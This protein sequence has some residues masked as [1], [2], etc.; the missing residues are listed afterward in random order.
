MAAGTI[1]TLML[2]TEEVMNSLA[3]DP[4]SEQKLDNSKLFT[5]IAISAPSILVQAS[6]MDLL[7]LHR[8]GVA[9][10]MCDH[11]QLAEWFYTRALEL[12]VA[13]FGSLSAEATKH[14]NFLA[15]LY[16]AWK[17]FALAEQYVRESLA[18]Y[19]CTLG[20][21]H[22][23]T[24]MTWFA[25]ALVLMQEKK[26]Q[27]SQDAYA[28]CNLRKGIDA[29]SNDDEHGWS[30]LTLKVTGLAA[31]KY[32]QKSYDESIELFRYCVLQEANEAWPGNL[33]I[34]KNLNSLAILCRSQRHDREADM[35]AKMSRSM[36]KAV[37]DPRIPQSN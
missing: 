21:E 7:A 2:A 27:E 10:R 24:R 15:G 4:L 6:S 20:A 22:M 34:A 16:L 5:Q 25:L 37:S 28:K 23:H 36:L 19:N 29:M 12:A 8:I 17:K 9:A 32:E 35:F 30:M 3:F 11:Y 33:I 31:Y 26:V 13:E 18:F 1:S 14:R